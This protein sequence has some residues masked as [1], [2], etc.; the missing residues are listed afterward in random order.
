M[1]DEN[2]GAVGKFQRVAMLIWLVE[3]YLAK[4]R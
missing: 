1:G 3:V 2:D 4:P